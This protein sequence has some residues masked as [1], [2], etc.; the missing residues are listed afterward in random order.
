[1]KKYIVVICILTCIKLQAQKL[2]LGV[3]AG[4]NITSVVVS[5]KYSNLGPAKLAPWF[6]YYA[7]GYAK[8]RLT[9]KQALKFFVQAEKRSIRMDG[10]QLTD[11]NGNP[12]NDI[13]LIVSNNYI[14][15]GAL[16]F[17]RLSKYSE[18][19]IGIDN[20]I[21]LSSTSYNSFFKNY[22]DSKSGRL[23]NEYFKPYL[24]SIPVQVI[25]NLNRFAICYSIDFGLMNRINNSGGVYK[26]FEYVAQLGLSYSLKR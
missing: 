26:Q 2:S 8:Y 22:P 6:G 1:M 23:K 14:N 16:Y 3:E 13:N 11:P 19:G 24:V 15:V 12:L 9:D 7:G 17:F 25:V 5:S 20:H 10:I 18:L 4:G 21:L